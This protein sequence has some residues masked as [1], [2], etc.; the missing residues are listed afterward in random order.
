MAIIAMSGAIT[1]SAAS[2]MNIGVSAVI[3]AVTI[4]AIIVIAAAAAM[5]LAAQLSVQS[6]VERLVIV[7]HGAANGPLAQL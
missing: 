3:I 7:L 2:G 6:P 5:A 1:T 4:E